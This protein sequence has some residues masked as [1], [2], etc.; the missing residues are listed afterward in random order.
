MANNSLS[1]QGCCPLYNTSDGEHFCVEQTESC[2][3][4]KDVKTSKVVKSIKGASFRRPLT[5]AYLRFE[6]LVIPDG[7]ILNTVFCHACEKQ[8]PAFVQMPEGFVHCVE[9]RVSCHKESPY[10]LS[11]PAQVFY[12]KGLSA[13][14][15]PTRV[16]VP[17]TTIVPNADRTVDAIFRMFHFDACRETGFESDGIWVFRMS[18]SCCDVTVRTSLADKVRGK[19]IACSQFLAV[20]QNKVRKEN[21]NY[22]Q[23]VTDPINEPV[24]AELLRMCLCPG[25]Y[26][27]LETQ[28]LRDG[29]FSCATDYG[30]VMYQALYTTFLQH[31]MEFYVV[32]HFLSLCFR[33]HQKIYVDCP[34]VFGN[35][36]DTCVI[37]CCLNSNV[38][39]ETLSNE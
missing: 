21:A 31:H 23:W 2:A 39:I 20:F 30:V 10:L 11:W 35:P 33:A 9:C 38:V 29:W 34:Y 6:D 25:A 15:Q 32:R 27:D 5:C 12:Y 18:S 26:I 16:K 19:V 7:M 1:K 24:D 37:G 28:V 4:S 14:V 36:V 8:K 17:T 22:I 3:P 13:A